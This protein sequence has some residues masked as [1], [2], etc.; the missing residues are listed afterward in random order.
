MENEPPTTTQ[1]VARLLRHEIGELLQTVYATVA[2]LS[3]RLPGGATLE[4]ELL[5]NLEHR[6]EMCRFELDAV[7]DLVC[8]VRGSTQEIDLDRLVGAALLQVRP[9]FPHLTIEESRGTAQ[10]IRA[11]SR[12][13]AGAV[14][15][16][17][18]ALCQHA[19]KRVV[20]RVERA[21]GMACVRLH[22]DG[23][24]VSD[25][26]RLWIQQP[27]TTTQQ[28]MLGVALALAQRALDPG[29]GRVTVSNQGEGV[30]VLL[31]SP[32]APGSEV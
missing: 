25:E 18:F 16:L 26:Q 7:V 8:G 20:V 11:D 2:I 30:E 13:V 9:R 19:R 4:R 17:L 23:F 6:A 10:V 21:D 24:G 31:E 32:I 15:F 12:L 22:R 3:D 1:V 27:F 14:P 28:S 29:T 5:G